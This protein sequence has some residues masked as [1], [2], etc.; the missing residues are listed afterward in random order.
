[1]TTDWVT[2]TRCWDACSAGGRLNSHT[3]IPFALTPF[4]EVAC[5]ESPLLDWTEE[6]VWDMRRIHEW[7]PVRYSAASNGE[8]P[9]RVLD[10]IGAE[11]TR[12]DA[13]AV[14]GAL[15]LL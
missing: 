14:C 7:R 1:V 8:S 12:H 5:T 9:F 10:A 6:F 3:K 11:R 2:A 4:F 13:Y 15:F